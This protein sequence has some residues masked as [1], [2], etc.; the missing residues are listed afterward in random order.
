MHAPGGVVRV[1]MS[2]AQLVTHTRPGEWSHQGEKYTRHKRNAH[3]STSM[4]VPAQTNTLTSTALT[5]QKKKMR[6]PHTNKNI[7]TPAAVC[8]HL[9]VLCVRARARVCVRVLGGDGGVGIGV[10]VV[11]IVGVCVCVCVCLWLNFLFTPD[12]VE[13]VEVSGSVCG[14]GGVCLWLA[15]LFWF[16]GALCILCVCVD[17]SGH[18][19][20]G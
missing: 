11:I 3:S 18:L 9:V 20:T 13:G 15:F 14:S 19:F 6:S 1:C 4:H 16:V 2:A 5:H 10:V 17:V 12:L 8:T 7:H